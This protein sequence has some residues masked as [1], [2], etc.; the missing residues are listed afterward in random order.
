MVRPGSPSATD[1]S[2]TVTIPAPSPESPPAL[3]EP[4]RESQVYGQVRHQPRTGDEELIWQSK[5]AYV[6]AG[7]IFGAL[8]LFTLPLWIVLFRLTDP[9]S[10]NGAGPHVGSLVALCMMLMGAFLTGATTWM[11][12]VEM[13]SRA[14][15][16][17]TL[18]RSG[19]YPQPAV[20][21]PTPFDPAQLGPSPGE[22]NQP[23][24][25]PIPG[26]GAPGG[27]RYQTTHRANDLLGTFSGAR[28][29]FGQAQ[30]ALLCVALAL[31]LGATVLSL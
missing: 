16:V 22:M 15:M 27:V 21:D 5:F 1:D 23:V 17:D 7:I 6:T 25:A 10:N 13:R 19:P 29:A 20:F 11:I 18:A 26:P 9:A 14:R 28:N 8:V 30:I 2:P 3:L 4:T 24:T 31:F 12:I